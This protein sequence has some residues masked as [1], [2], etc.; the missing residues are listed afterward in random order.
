VQGYP[1]TSL[2]QLQ[3]A[4]WTPD[5]ILKK[6]LDFIDKDLLQLID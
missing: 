6:G 1:A 3:D 5:K 4:G 2:F